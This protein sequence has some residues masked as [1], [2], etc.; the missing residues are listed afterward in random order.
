M[1]W[2]HA[3]DGQQ[4]GPVSEADFARLVATGVVRDDTLV[5]HEGM[6]G[7]QPY[8]SVRP[9][10]PPSN[11]VHFPPAQDSPTPPVAEAGA[12]AFVPC[13]GCGGWFPPEDTL[14]MGGQRV[15]A[16][17]KP[18]HLQRLLEGAAP[19]PGP[20]RTAGGG[21]TATAAEIMARDYQID[22]GERISEAWTF[23]FREPGV[24]LFGGILVFLVIMA[25][26]M[27]PFGVGAIL[28]LLLT[29]PMR[30]GLVLFYLRRQRGETVQLGDSFGGF[31]PRFWPLVGAHLSPTILSS[32][33]WMP[34]GA[35]LGLG[36][37]GQF[38]PGSPFQ[39]AATSLIV[40]GSAALLIGGGVGVWLGV[41]WIYALPLV[42][43]KGYGIWEAMNLSRQVVKRHFWQN[44][45]LG[46]VFMLVTTAGSLACCV[47]VLVAI[48]VTAAAGTLQ[49]ERLFGDLAPV[50][51]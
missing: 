2:Y 16:N 36:L 6:S 15:C 24:L 34:G 9:V 1:N 23:L 17:C 49:Y 38:S 45:W 20:T 28:S 13:A 39:G 35:L 12:G 7:W 47:G 3:Q 48:P 33:P 11:P 21:T 25:V 29:G 44:L 8:S 4:I 51:R 46:I 32:L 40:A 43:D 19:P 50:R 41:S 27:I 30:G 14:E 42:A 10:P 5:W 31:G 22:P 37:I 26:G 18:A